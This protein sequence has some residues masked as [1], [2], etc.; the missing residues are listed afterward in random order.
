MNCNSVSNVFVQNLVFGTLQLK[1]EDDSK[2][3]GFQ[4]EEMLRKAL[5]KEREKWHR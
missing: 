5:R 4:Q 3:A 1:K 2:D